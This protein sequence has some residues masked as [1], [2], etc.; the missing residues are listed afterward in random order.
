LAES[1]ERKRDELIVSLIKFRLDGELTQFD[2]LDNKALGFVGA[3]TFV[4][5]LTLGIATLDTSILWGYVFLPVLFFTGICHYY[6]LL[7]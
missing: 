2:S 3:L 4:A 5:G 1:D 6:P 7:F